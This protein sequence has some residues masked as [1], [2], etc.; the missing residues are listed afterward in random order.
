MRQSSDETVTVVHEN[1]EE[2]LGIVDEL[3]QQG[4]PVDSYHP[5]ISFE[6]LFGDHAYLGTIVLWRELRRAPISQATLD[7]MAGLESFLIYA[8]SDIVLRH[9]RAEP[10]VGVFDDALEQLTEEAGLSKTEVRVVLLLLLGH[11]YKDMADMLSVSMDTVK[12]HLKTIYRKTGTRS[13]SELFAKYFTPR[14]DLPST[15]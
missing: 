11:S 1:E 5:P 14:L 3:R 7:T 6:Y 15:D 10:L 2:A 13:G 9:K 4:F 8:L 12:Y